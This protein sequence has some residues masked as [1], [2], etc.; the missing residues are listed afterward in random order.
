MQEHL[1]VSSLEL[2]PY[3][4]LYTA[5][6]DALA[7]LADTGNCLARIQAAQTAPVLPKASQQ[8]RRLLDG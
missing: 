8:C 1:A 5:G 7:V 2:V 4:G 3:V 6:S